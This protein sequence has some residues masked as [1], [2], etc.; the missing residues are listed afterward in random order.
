MDVWR[1]LANDNE[2]RI[3]FA[4]VEEPRRFS[5]LQ[6]DLRINP[7]ALSAALK[8]LDKKGLVV[9]LEYSTDPRKYTYSLAAKDIADGTFFKEF[10]K[11]L[12]EVRE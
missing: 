12:E 3:L 2:R 4:V 8:R 11:E 7:R 10:A 9:K 1:T 6:F 5:D